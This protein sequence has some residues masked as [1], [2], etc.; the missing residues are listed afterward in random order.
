MGLVAAE[1]A[2][3]AT[4]A[5]EYD[6]R[7]PHITRLSPELGW[8]LKPGAGDIGEH[9]WRRPV[10]PRAKSPGHFR[11]V[12]IGD[13]TTFG[14]G[15]SWSDAWPHQLEV[16]LNQDAEWSRSHRITEVLNL[17]VLMY[18]P[19]QSLL[20][21][22][23]YGLA[24][25]PDLV[26]FHLCSDDF[27]D[28][29]FDY[30]WKMNFDTK[31]YKPF[32]RLEEGRLILARDRAPDQTDA[33]GNL[34]E[35]PRQILPEWQLYLFSFL[36]TRAG[37]FFRGEAPSKQEGP[38]KAHWP[39]HDSFHAEYSASRPLV[40][41]LIKEMSRLSRANGAEFLLT[42]SPQHL[43]SA[44]DVPPWRAASFRRDYQEDARLAG[45]PAIDCVPEYFAQGGNDRFQLHD[46]VMYLN[47]KG[48]AL[49]ART[50]LRGIKELDSRAALGLSFV[51]DRSHVSPMA[52]A[53]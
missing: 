36:R 26:I 9:G 11:I 52:I 8:A 44:D 50:T 6:P 1:V 49:I 13:S 4:P 32:F 47:P 48:N 30:Y 27:A 3:R 23:N 24:Y 46:V 38:T 43:R 2:C 16:L 35:P 33:Q 40:W 37:K 29:S 45:I 51:R 5:T 17:G 42:L 18:G 25:S 34:I 20:A 7:L 10:Y 19:D 14:V 53:D 31:M 28:A 39:V 15:C 12:C 41:A 21:L 22:K